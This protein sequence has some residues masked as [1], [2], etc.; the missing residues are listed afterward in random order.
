VA[1]F[2]QEHQREQ[3]DRFGLGQQF[4]QQSTQAYRLGGQALPD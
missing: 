2:V 1:R 4:D 3:A